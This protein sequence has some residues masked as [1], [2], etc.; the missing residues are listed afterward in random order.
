[1]THDEFGLPT[2][3][4]SAAPYRHADGTFPDPANRE[5][6]LR[7]VLH[8]AGVELGTYDER[9]LAWLANLDWP[10]FATITSWIERSR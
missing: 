1:M 9:I 10:T 5:A 7:D 2:G 3:P 8:R 6:I 4:I